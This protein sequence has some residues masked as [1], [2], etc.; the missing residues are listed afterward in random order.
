MPIVSTALRHGV[1]Q[2]ADALDPEANGLAGLQESPAAH[3]DARRRPSHD[4]VAGLQRDARRELRDLLRRVEDHP[5]G[6]RVLH[7][8]VADPELHAEVLRIL[9]L[10]G[11]NDPRA[12]RT[13][14][15]EA[16]L[17][18]SVHAGP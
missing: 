5:P 7:E 8:L 15:L 1:G 4:Q 17:A 10:A 16:L 13:P 9:D 11:G 12:Q 3:P 14:A 6:V 18:E 2:L